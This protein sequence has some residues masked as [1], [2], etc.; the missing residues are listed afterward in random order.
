M[1]TKMKMGPKSGDACC[2]GSCGC[3]DDACC[4]SSCSSSCTKTSGLV[5]FMLG[6]LFGAVLV[7]FIFFYQVMMGAD[8]QSAILKYKTTKSTLT[9]PT[10]MQTVDTV[11][12]DGFGSTG[13][14]G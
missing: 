14:G 12:T 1:P 6:V 11:Q 2:G 8:Y 3:G 10:Q 7:G 4:S 5:W 13:V 9:A